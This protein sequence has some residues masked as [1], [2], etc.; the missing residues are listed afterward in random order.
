[1]QIIWRT[2]ARKL[3]LPSTIFNTP[4]VVS[5]PGSIHSE[6]GWT[7]ETLK[8][9]ARLRAKTIAPGTPGVTSLIPVD[10]ATRLRMASLGQAQAIFDEG[11]LD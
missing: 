7:R 10:E 5:T 11:K 6:I 4:S 2:R 1:L 8:G 9:F 3:A